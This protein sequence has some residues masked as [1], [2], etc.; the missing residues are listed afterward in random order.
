MSRSKNRIASLGVFLL[1]MLSTSL[2]VKTAF[3]QSDIAKTKSSESQSASNAA[4]KGKPTP[5]PTPVPTPT[6]SVD[7][8]CYFGPGCIDATFGINGVR[9]VLDQSIDGAVTQADGKIVGVGS[10]GVDAAGF[11]D[12]LI[13]R[14]NPDGSLD[15]TFGSVDPQNPLLRLGFKY[16]DVDSLSNRAHEVAIQPDGKIVVGGIRVD[17]GSVLWTIV[18]YEANGDRDTTFGN[19]GVVRSNIATIFEGLALQSDGRIVAAGGDWVARFNYDGTPD[20]SFGTGSGAIDL[21]P[22]VSSSCAVIQTVQNQERILLGG[23]QLVT[24]GGRGRLTNHNEFS[25]VRLLPSGQLDPSFGSGGKVNTSFGYTD[26]L[27]GLAVDSSNRIV[28][29]GLVGT[30]GPQ[31]AGVARYSVNGVLDLSFGNGTG[32]V[33]FTVNGYRTTSYAILLQ[34]DGKLVSVGYAESASTTNLVLVRYNSDG[35]PDATFGPGNFGPGI[36]T[37]DINGGTDY[38]FS[39][40]M[41]LDGGI[42]AIGYASNIA[43]FTRYIP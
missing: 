34:S 3:A 40:T 43:F 37:A 14:L 35:S 9:L 12:A 15:T 42:I 28:A 22:L 6:P 10:G 32:K 20:S 41:L 26:L 39:G 30:A 31:A 1:A 25:L 21:S 8:K 27:K 33:S 17:N 7:T 19:N 13:V 24:T 36:V 2:L 11:A 38:G 5:T 18:R 16:D 29:S 4:A 23:Y